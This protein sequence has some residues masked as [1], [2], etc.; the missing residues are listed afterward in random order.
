MNTRRNRRNGS[1]RKQH[2][3]AMSAGLRSKFA[4]LS[5][6][7]SELQG[8]VEAECG[9][10]GGGTVARPA[11]RAAVR[12]ASPPRAAAAGAA[13]PARAVSR[14]RSAAPKVTNNV[15]I[16][17]NGR[18]R[19]RSS[20]RNVTASYFLRQYKLATAAV[21]KKYEAS[22]AATSWKKFQDTKVTI[23]P[24]SIKAFLSKEFPGSGGG[25]AAAGGGGGGV[26]KA[27]SVEEAEALM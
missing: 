20:G 12:A 7:V 22:Q 16:G 9:G 11:P 15:N 6:R 10:G 21:G 5:E 23:S 19:S 25:N 4:E 1:M 26:P 18:I 27:I 3:G 2:G 13:A 17:S 24:E 14:G 8:M